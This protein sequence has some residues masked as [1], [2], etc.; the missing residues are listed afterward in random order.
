MTSDVKIPEEV[1]DAAF[2][3]LSDVQM[4]DVDFTRWD[5]VAS[6]ERIALALLAAERRG[7]EKAAEVA[8]A[9]DGK[10]PGGFGNPDFGPNVARRITAAIRSLG[11]KT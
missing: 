1:R 11:E 8:A 9:D 2:S 6:L 3:L 5:A 10:A 4:K 7:L